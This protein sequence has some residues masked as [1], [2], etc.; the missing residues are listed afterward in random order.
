[1]SGNLLKLAGS[2]TGMA[3]RVDRRRAPET[4]ARILDSA[5]TLFARRGFYGVSLRDIAAE[6]GVPLALSHYHFGSKENL[7]SAIIDRRAG[8]HAD[9]IAAA[10]AGA[11]LV[12]GSRG[13]R[14]AAI[15]RALIS[16]IAERFVHGGPGWK[17]YIRLLAFV[18]NHPQ[19]EDYVSPFKRHY[20]SL[21]QSFVKALAAIHPEIAPLDVQWGF[22]FYQ[23]AITHILVE[24]GMLERQSGGALGSGDF[25]A[26]VERIV[27][28]FS[29]GFL[30]LGA[31]D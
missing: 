3:P 18:A 29:A 2:E 17:N 27:P 19:E 14:R 4:A 9:S 28:F 7:F 15:I 24:S 22:F 26:M 30:G 20:D 11:M 5:E 1:M 25:A 10:L 13:M 8:E 31:V 12:E 6:A 23:A 21:I 16:P